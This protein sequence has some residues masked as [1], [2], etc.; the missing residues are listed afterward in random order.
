[1]SVR[2][3]KIE[4]LI[5]EELSLIILYKMRDP[6]FGFLTLTKVKVTP[7]TKIAKIYISSYEKEK[8]QAILQKLQSVKGFLRTELAKKVSLRAVPD[9]EFF[10]DDTSDYVEKMEILFKMIHENDSK[11]PE[12]N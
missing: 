12:Q 6:I 7:D 8:R 10:I 9:L 5:K 1:M 2:L 11:K 3:Q 4:S